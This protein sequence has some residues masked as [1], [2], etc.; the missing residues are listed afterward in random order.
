MSHTNTI[1]E[2]INNHNTPYC[3][4]CL[5]INCNILPRQSVNQICNKLSKQGILARYRNVC[6][7]CNSIKITS[8]IVEK[9]DI[10]N[11]VE[12]SVEITNGINKKSK[13]SEEK[14]YF[15]VEKVRNSNTDFIEVSLLFQEKNIGDIFKEYTSSTLRETVEKDRYNKL[16]EQVYKNYKDYLDY[17]LGKFLFYLKTVNS[18]FY[19]LFLNSH[20]DSQ[21]CTFSFIDKEFY[22][23]KGIYAY[24][25]ND[26]IV[27]VGRV[28]G[29][30]TFNTRVNQGYA[31]ISPKNCYI[32]GQSTNC[33]INSLVNNNYGS[34]K[35]FLLP[36]DSDAEIIKF[37]KIL[38]DILKPKWNIKL[39]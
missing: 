32:D 9:K 26:K 8:T 31:N 2:Y 17:P 19:K 29:I 21:Y 20:G 18:D 23:A 22:E 7:S 38:I 30:N 28:K 36:L 13:N 35:L 12:H 14:G 27:Y 15:N 3:D 4:D 34:I 1:L 6:S 10:S 33:R 25:L 37:E 11:F 16:K 5:S 24:K 39:K